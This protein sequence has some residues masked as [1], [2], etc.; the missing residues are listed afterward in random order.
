MSDRMTDERLSGIWGVLNNART[1]A[2]FQSLIGAARAHS[3]VVKDHIRP[4]PGERIL[5]I[6]S[7][8][9]GIVPFLPEMDYLG[10]DIEPAYVE[11]ATARFS[12]RARFLCTDALSLSAD[13][14]GTFNVVTARGFMH[15]LSDDKVNTLIDSIPGLLA[16][17]GRFVT[18][19][20]ARTS[21]QNPIARFMI[22]QDRGRHIRQPED[23]EAL[24]GRR[25]ETS[26]T[27]RTDLLRIP[28]THA[29]CEGFP[30]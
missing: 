9:A 22:N 21:P 7:G 30:L 11:E 6:G 13:E 24:V 10:V 25:F 18:V 23:Y 5:D 1:L 19:D 17:G 28:Y 27:V 16:P 14:I 4:E 12:P 8:L 26:V 15:H 29:I 3:R 20:P 2:S